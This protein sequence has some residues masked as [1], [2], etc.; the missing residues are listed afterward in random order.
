MR[1]YNDARFDDEFDDFD[2]FD[3]DEVEPDINDHR[4]HAP[5]DVR[6]WVRSETC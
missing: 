5:D 6:E 3:D 4:F 2:D 1:T